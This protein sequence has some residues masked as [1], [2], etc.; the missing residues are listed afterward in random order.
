M[1]KIFLVVFEKTYERFVQKSNC[2]KSTDEHFVQKIIVRKV[3][4][5]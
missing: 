3:I 1:K 4:L 2:T 5:P